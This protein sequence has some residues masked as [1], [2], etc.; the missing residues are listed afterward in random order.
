MKSR[1]IAALAAGL[2]SAAPA[3]AAVVT[4]DFEGPASFESVGEYYSSLGVVF[5]PDAL[6]LRNDDFGP[7]FSGAPSPLDVLGPDPTGL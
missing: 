1:F 5:G 2:F 7:Y 4:I 6:A 3:F